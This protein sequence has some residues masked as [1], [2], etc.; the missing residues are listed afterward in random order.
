MPAALRAAHPVRAM[1][2]SPPG[3]HQQVRAC[4]LLQVM[5]MHIAI[6]GFMT[7]AL[8][9]V[10]ACAG[11]PSTPPPAAATPPAG[12]AAAGP[13]GT[14]G[15]GMW[16]DDRPGY[17]PS[18]V[19]TVRGR[20]VRVDRIATAPGRAGGLHLAIETS[21]GSLLS[22]HLGP[23]GYVEGQGLTF[24]VGDTVEVTGSRASWSGQPALIARMIVKGDREIVLRDEAGVPMWSRGRG[25]FAAP[26]GP[27]AGPGQPQ[28]GGGAALSGAERRALHDALD[29]EYRTLAT[30]EQAIRDLGPGRPFVNIREA[31]LRHIDALRTLFVRYEVA[32]PDNPWP[33]RIARF[34]SVGEACQAGIDGELATAALYE[35]LMKTTQRDDLLAVFAYLQRAARENHLAAFRRCARRGPGGGPPGR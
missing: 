13:R 21:R 9:T 25:R 16:S 32:I 15:R 24:A 20:V 23:V 30:Y 29:Q 19:E 28:A 11:E 1:A 6:S 27:G 18:T 31:E 33:G 4:A 10:V 7:V 14:D 35:R 3:A 17:D 22:V 34:A 12:R 8:L 2:G 26:A 5:H